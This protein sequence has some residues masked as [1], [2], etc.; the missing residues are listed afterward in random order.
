MTLRR[1]L[2][3]ACAAA[4]ALGLAAGYGVA[5]QWIGTALAVVTGLAWLPARRYP[6]AWLPLICLFVSIGLAVVGR[7]TGAAPV[8]MIGGAALALAAWDLLLLDAALGSAA[9][10]EQTRAYEASHLRSLALAVGGGLV[11]ALLGR[12]LQL[13]ISFF[14]MAALVALAVFGLDRAWGYVKKTA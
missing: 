12:L 13:E 10:G 11:G 1:I 5:G 4:S 14:I 3:A 7:L 9:P 6:A 2:F 8:L